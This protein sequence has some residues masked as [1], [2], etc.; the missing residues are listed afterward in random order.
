MRRFMVLLKKEIGEL[1]TPQ[2]LL[3]LVVTVLIFMFIGNVVSS[4]EKQAGTTPVVVVDAD[5]SAAS[6]TIRDALKASGFRLVESDAP[7]VADAV[8]RAR[9]DRSLRLFIGIPKGFGASIDAGEQVRVEAYTVMRDFS[10]LA[11]R[12]AG[13]LK[14][15][16]AALNDRLSDQVIARGAPGLDPKTVKSPVGIDESVVVGDKTAH[17]SAEAVVGFISTQT[18][19]IPIVLF[20]VIIFAAQMIAT[21]IASEKE[22]K[23]LETLLASPVSRGA[24]VTAKMVAAALIALLSS[25]AYML[26]MRYYM[27]S[28]T[29]SFGAGPVGGPDPVMAQLG[30]TFKPIDYALLLTVLFAGILV[31]L[32]ISVILGAFAENVRSVQTLL[33]PLTVA[34]MIPYFLTLFVDIQ[35]ASPAVRWLV[36]AIPFSH[37]FLAAPNLFFG[38]Y[39]SVL[40]GIAYELA[41]FVAFAWIAARVFASDRILTLKLA[42]PRLRG[43]PF[44]RRRAGERSDRG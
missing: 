36:L 37:P 11:T 38:D 30:L 27:N 10:F 26:G 8:S 21:T 6:G 17:T 15:V 2:V 7:S 5:R 28:L 9:E 43:L 20:I 35:S 33:T 4:Q 34:I 18:T 22:N 32:A 41:W 19:F 3:P 25:G 14:G 1:L 24:L 39:R 29:K 16:V 44:Q 13:A 12:D 23:T 31:A 40:L 42:G